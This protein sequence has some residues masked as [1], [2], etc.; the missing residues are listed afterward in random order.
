M[1][2]N[3]EVAVAKEVVVTG[4]SMFVWMLVLL[5][6]VYFATVTMFLEPKESVTSILLG[7]LFILCA[8]LVYQKFY[9]KPIVQ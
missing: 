6:M 2:R 1:G 4:I 8:T 3:R 7:Y 5:S 9:Q